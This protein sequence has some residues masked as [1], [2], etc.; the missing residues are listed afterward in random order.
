[1]PRDLDRRRL[2]TVALLLD[3][4]ASTAGST[5]SS[6]YAK[7]PSPV[8]AQLLRD[9]GPAAAPTSRVQFPGD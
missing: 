9:R 1:M 8:V 4:G 3:A 7:P 6:D 5:L 2:E